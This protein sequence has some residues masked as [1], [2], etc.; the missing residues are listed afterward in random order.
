MKMRKFGLTRHAD[1]AKHGSACHHLADLH[2]HGSL[3]H[4]A[5]LGFPPARMGDGNAV[6]T[7]APLNTFSTGH[8][9]ADIDHAIAHSSYDARRGSEYLYAA[10]L[11]GHGGDAQI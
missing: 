9:H 3:C 11:L 1:E 5:V 7:C 8:T 6:A 2:P 10:P 4:M